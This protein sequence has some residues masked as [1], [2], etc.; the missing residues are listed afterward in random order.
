MGLIL[1]HEGDQHLGSE[2][3]RNAVSGKNHFFVK[4]KRSL[5]GGCEAAESWNLP[6]SVHQ[7]VVQAQEAGE[8]L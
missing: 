2:L 4:M 7:T 1:P 6:S 8:F 3:R 5:P